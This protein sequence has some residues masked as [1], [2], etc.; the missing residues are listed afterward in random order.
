MP[1]KALRTAALDAA[2]DVG[3]DAPAPERRPV[4]APDAAAPAQGQQPDAAVQDAAAPTVA[5]AAPTPMPTGIDPLV[6]PILDALEDPALKRLP[7]E[8]GAAFGG[9]PALAAEA[10]EVAAGFADTVGET[11]QSMLSWLQTDYQ[12]TLGLAMG[13]LGPA[14]LRTVHKKLKNARKRLTGRHRPKADSAVVD[15]AMANERVEQARWLSERLGQTR[16]AWLVAKREQLNFKAHPIKAPR[17][18][19]WKLFQPGREV[20]KPERIPSSRAAAKEQ[21]GVAPELRGFLDQV[22]DQFSAFTRDT[23]EGHGA[24]RFKGAGFS[25]D[26]RLPGSQIDE[27]G[28]YAHDDAVAFFLAVDAVAARVNAQWLGLYNDYDVALE[29]STKATRG[30]VHFTGQPNVEG[31]AALNYHG[32]GPLKLHIHLDVRLDVS[33]QPGK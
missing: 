8:S 15:A 12:Q 14:W 25:V 29:V 21:P 31:K 22:A 20:P 4:E 18:F 24:R 30:L 11:E 28:F 19:D 9:D 26:I 1:D 10:A 27:R 7:L 33:L 3:E 23:Y 17:G 13:I 6:A 2:P 32:P 5:P 16:H